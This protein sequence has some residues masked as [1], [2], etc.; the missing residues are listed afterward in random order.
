M[1]IDATYPQRQV[2]LP[3]L[4][5]T[6]V[7]TSSLRVKLKKVV[8]VPKGS[9]DAVF[10]KSLDSSELD[11]LKLKR[12]N[13][14][15]VARRVARKPQYPS[16]FATEWLHGFGDEA[17]YRHHSTPLAEEEILVPDDTSKEN[18]LAMAWMCYDA[19]AMQNSSSGWVDVGGG[20]NSTD[21]FGW[22]KDGVRGY[23]FTDDAE[24]VTIV[25]IKG[26]STTYLGIGG[27]GTSKK[28]KFNDNMMFSCCC[29]KVDL[30]W[31][32]I[33]DC[34]DPTS[35]RTCSS[36]CLH[37]AINFTDSYY[38]MSQ[39][40]FKLVQ[41][42]HS[43]TSIWFT[44]HSLGGALASLLGLTYNLP[45]WGYEAPGDLLYAERIGLLPSASVLNAYSG[46]VQPLFESSSSAQRYG[47][48]SKWMENSLVRHWGNTGDP[49]FMGECNG[50]TSSCY[51]AGYA[52]ESKC[53]VGKSCVYDIDQAQ[54]TPP[55]VTPIPAPVPTDDTG[56]DPPSDPWY[57]CSNNDESVSGSW[58]D[59]R[60]WLGRASCP[61]KPG[62][63]NSN[64]TDSEV[65]A[66]AHLDIRNH[67]IEKAIEWY[68]EPWNGV[69]KCAVDS[70]CLDCVAW[71]FTR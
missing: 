67:R 22:D 34:V 60:C 54:P 64:C 51:Y 29:A 33:C 38:H 47:A 6:R 58:W 7:D 32:P 53:H 39:K 68:F 45:A 11:L 1:P 30:M 49:V 4:K 9:H 16:N 56:P 17:L 70:D 3:K 40:L 59:W 71:N 18:A 20:W 25:A 43:N 27:G 63:D 57:D 28:D 62:L 21:G 61:N 23:V 19:Y 42:Q 13:Y 52:L 10:V 35:L 5:P 24:T 66:L 69:P 41:S 2:H 15:I 65:G 26:T 12:P 44:G 37:S 8:H 50:P 36:S 46:R 48:Y 55:R 31:R 14:H